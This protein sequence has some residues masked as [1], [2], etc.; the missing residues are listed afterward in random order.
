MV[1]GAKQRRQF[2]GIRSGKRLSIAAI[3]RF[4]MVRGRAADEP[5]LRH[6]LCLERVRGPAGESVR[7]EKGS[8]GKCLH[9]AVVVF[10]LAFIPRLVPHA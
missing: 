5:C 3:S 1:S 7:V 10:A 8:D 4:S 2:I 6:C 9:L